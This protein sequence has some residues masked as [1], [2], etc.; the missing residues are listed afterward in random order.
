[1]TETE[2]E[3]TKKESGQNKMCL[4]GRFDPS[5]LKSVKLKKRKK[6]KD[7]VQKEKTKFAK[8][9]CETADDYYRL[10][11]ET[12]FENYYEKIKD[13]TFETDYIELSKDDCKILMNKH[14]E[15]IKWDKQKTEQK[16]DNDNKQDEKDEKDEIIGIKINKYDYDRKHVQT[17]ID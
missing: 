10:V 1:M 17:L 8:Q 16:G 9:L 7:Q 14:E 6:D 12:Y 4:G 3:K 11:K 5:E 2:K 13:F 15:Y